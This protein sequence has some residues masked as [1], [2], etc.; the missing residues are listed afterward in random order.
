MKTGQIIKPLYLLLQ[1]YSQYDPSILVPLPPKT[2]I[3]FQHIDD[4]WNEMISLIQH[5]NQVDS[6]ESSTILLNQKKYIDFRMNSQL[7][8]QTNFSLAIQDTY[9]Q[10]YSSSSLTYSF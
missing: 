2:N 1:L 4:S 6:I 3:Q 9:Y 5:I 10:V 7:F 8:F